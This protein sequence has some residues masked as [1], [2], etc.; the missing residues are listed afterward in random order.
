MATLP[1]TGS[2]I[3]FGQVNKGF[4]NNNPGSAGDAPSG[5]QNIKL[6][7]VLGSNPIYTVNQATGTQI[8]FSITF[9]GKSTPY[10]F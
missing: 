5:G 10:S 9:G 6:S 2:A 3:S 8:S 7:G 1:A 4:T